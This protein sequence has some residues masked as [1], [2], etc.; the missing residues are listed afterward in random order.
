M[1]I[2]FFISGKLFFDKT[3]R[4]FLSQKIIRIAVWG[5][6]LGMAAMIVS[7]AVITGF[8]NEIKNKIV[9]FQSHIQILNFDSNNSYETEPVSKNQSWVTAVRKINGVKDLKVFATKPAILKSADFNQG[10]VFKGL[11][12][13][14]NWE[15][16]KSRLISGS[17]PNLK[18]PGRSNEIIISE[19]TARQLKLK[20]GDKPVII[21]INVAE[22]T[23]VLFQPV[24]SGIYRTNLE[25]FDRLFAF[26]DLRQVQRANNWQ[27]DM[28]SGFEVDLASFEKISQV[29]K[30]IKELVIVYDE[31]KK[32]T[33]KTEN[34]I[35]QNPQ[36]F[37]W[38]E[39]T[40]MNV[41]ILLTLISV[42]AGFCM[43]SGLLVLIIERSNMIG[44]LKALGMTNSKLRMIFIY[45]TVFLSSKGILWGNIIGIA[46]I[47]LQNR[48][49]FI[50]LDPTT[51]Y[52]DY[53]PVNISIIHIFLLNIST[54]SLI[55]IMLI[56][57]SYLVGRISPDKSIRFD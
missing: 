43:A 13:T 46:F 6:S 34:V 16:L 21:F 18:Q 35:R 24:I 55:F 38:L 45:I 44:L 12:S 14:F 53:M 20:K 41:W 36:I 11:D 42:V 54:I 28:V 23:P 56:F 32:T 40:D 51:Y 15:Y 33:F 27:P 10:I 7:I 3:N 29:E 48:F 50:K 2:S 17:I 22:N 49:H 52:M 5:I 47:F 4:R 39:V 25:E 1:N 37:E 57:P 26:G 31:N 9:E 30:Q 19:Q 8:K